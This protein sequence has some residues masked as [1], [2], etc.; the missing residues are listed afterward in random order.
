LIVKHVEGTVSY[1]TS[2]ITTLS[3]TSPEAVLHQRV[4]DT[5]NTERGLNDVG[6]KFAGVL[7]SLAELD[8]NRVL[9]DLDLAVSNASNLEGD[10]AV[11]AQ[12]LG[13]LLSLLLWCGQESSLDS[14]GILLE[15]RTKLLPLD[16][17]L[18]LLND[19]RSLTLLT[20]NQGSTGLLGVHAQIVSTSVGTAN[21]LDPARAGE[22]LSIPTV[23]SVVSHLVGHVLTEAQLGHVNTNFLQELVD[24]SKEVAQGLVIDKTILDSL[25]NLD[26]LGLSLAR[27]LSITVEKDELDVLDLVE[28]GVLLATLGIDKVLDLSHEELTDSQETGTRRDLV[29]V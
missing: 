20:H 6:H 15:L 28:S 21:T 4:E 19:K 29:T 22:Q 26:S 23:A 13:K 9:V 8:G 25:A 12:L 3:T 27:K 18:P 17:D 7:N 5:A 24:A 1:S 14:L 10:A 2:L 16:I 11:V